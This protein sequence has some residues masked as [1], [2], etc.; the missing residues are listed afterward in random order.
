[1][2]KG[3]FVAS[4]CMALGTV[5]CVPA[6]Q[7]TGQVFA[8]NSSV[9][10]ANNRSLAEPTLVDVLVNQLGVNLQQAM[11]GVGS[12]FALAQQR[13][14]PEDFMQLASSVPDMDQYLA[15]VPHSASNFQLGA[16][17]NAIGENAIGFG[18]LGALSGSFQALGMNPE[19]AFQ[20]VPVVIQYLQQQSELSAVSLLQNALY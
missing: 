7:P 19:M 16:A 9:I 8:D 17:A 10:Q 1:M 6:E 4:I 12:V 2:N 11:G 3:L 20:F 14:R 18:N 15:A 13:M 5:A